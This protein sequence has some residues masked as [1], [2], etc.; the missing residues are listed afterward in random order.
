M[1]EKI[2]KELAK[3]HANHQ[4][5]KITTLIADELDERKV[6]EEELKERVATLEEKTG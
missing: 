3:V 2:R 6:V 1:T 5:S 4:L